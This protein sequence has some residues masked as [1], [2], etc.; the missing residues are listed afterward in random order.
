MLDPRC[1]R[2]ITIASLATVI[3]LG[4][5]A[6]PANAD[7]ARL[8]FA[9]GTWS[10]ASYG[11]WIGDDR[12]T[13]AHLHVAVAFHPLDAF[14]IAL[15]AG[16]YEIWRRGERAGAG[17]GD[18]LLRWYAVREAWWALFVEAGCGVIV[19]GMDIPA[20][21]S[22]WNFTPQARGGVAFQVEPRVHVLMLAGW[23]HAST[24]GLEQP[25][26]GLNAA[27]VSIGLLVEP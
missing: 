27:N 15:E 23:W 24:A 3:G 7:D 19:A 2:A 22:S 20:Q 12:N 4:L 26:P 14:A 9:Q 21:T 17:S 5:G 16:A 1:T 8:P 10:L 13:I 11:G 18:L 25:N 6:S